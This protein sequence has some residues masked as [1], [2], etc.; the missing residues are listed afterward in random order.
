[1]QMPV[2]TAILGIG[3]VA[4]QQEVDVVLIHGISTI[5]DRAFTLFRPSFGHSPSALRFGNS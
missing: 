2:K 5:R 3:D 1:M 4:A